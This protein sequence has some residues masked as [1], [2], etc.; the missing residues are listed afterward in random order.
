[1]LMSITEMTRIQIYASLL[2][3]KLLQLL[4]FIEFVI[5]FVTGGILYREGDHAIQSNRILK[6][7]IA[8]EV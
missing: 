8:I 3:L 2:V 1:M 7:R 6:I 4:H 5:N